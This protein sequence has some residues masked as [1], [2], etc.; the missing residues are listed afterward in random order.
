MKCGVRKIAADKG[1]IKDLAAIG[2]GSI[3]NMANSFARNAQTMFNSFE[4]D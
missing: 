4:I 1:Q 2:F 3:Q